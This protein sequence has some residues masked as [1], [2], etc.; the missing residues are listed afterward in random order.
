M[1]DR[2]YNNRK[3]LMVRQ[4]VLRRDGYMCQLSKRYGKIVQANTVH[5]I[6]PRELFPEY[7]YELWNLISLSAEKHNELH[8]RNTNELTEQGVELLKRTARRNG[9]DV[10]MVYR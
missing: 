8:D 2:F 9:I 3:W 5:H 6:F 10:P 1:E 4:S 7:Q